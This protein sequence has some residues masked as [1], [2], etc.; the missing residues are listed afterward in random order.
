MYTAEYYSTLTKKEMLPQQVHCHN[1]G[2]LDGCYAQWNQPGAERRV[3]ARAWGHRLPALRWVGMGVE[4]V[5]SPA[6]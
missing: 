4:T 1:T 5:A 3:M 2:T 6:M